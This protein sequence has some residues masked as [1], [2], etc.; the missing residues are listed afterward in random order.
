M[1]RIGVVNEYIWRKSCITECVVDSLS[2]RAPARQAVWCGFKSRSTH[3]FDTI[4]SLYFSL[5]LRMFEN[6]SRVAIRQQISCFNLSMFTFTKSNMQVYFCIFLINLTK[7]FQ[8]FTCLKNFQLINQHK[9]L[10]KPLKNFYRQFPFKVH[11]A[12]TLDLDNS[13]SNGHSYVFKK[14]K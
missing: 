5:K 6:Y 7:Y 2:G 10:E 1:V 13:K 9:I 4:F 14:F 3:I 8:N 11:E 12:Y